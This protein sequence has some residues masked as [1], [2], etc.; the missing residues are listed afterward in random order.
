VYRIRLV[1]DSGVDLEQCSIS[2]PESGVHVTYDHLSFIPFQL[3]FG[4]NNSGRLGEF[5]VYVAFSNVYFR[6][7]KFSFQT[8]TIRKTGAENLRQKME[9]IYG[10]G[11]WSVCHA[12]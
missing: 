2:K 8:N 4:Y 9:S 3:T 5:I 1:P 10:D 12:Y 7:Q 11:F 6:R